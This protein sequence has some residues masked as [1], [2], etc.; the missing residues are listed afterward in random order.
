MKSKPIFLMVLAVLIVSLSCM[1]TTQVSNNSGQTQAPQLSSPFAAEATSPMSVQLAW[2]PVAG[3]QKYLLAVRLGD[4]EFFPIAELPADQTSFEDFP[5]PDNSELTYRLQS[6]TS[7]ATND[8]GTATVKTSEIEPNPL[9][10]QANDYAP[11]A[12]VPP[13]PDPN[14]PNVDPSAFY[15]P[16]FDPDHPESFDPANAMQQVQ[17][18]A[19]IGR[20]GG[21]LSITTPDNITYEL[22]FPPD[23]LEEST[24]ISLF[25]IETIDGLPFDGG[26]Q[27]AVRIEPDGLML[28]LPA[29]LRITQADAAPLPEGMVT[30]AFGF[31]GSGEE[32]HLLP[33]APAAQTGLYLGAGHVASLTAAPLRAGPLEKIALQQL[34][35]YGIGVA[36]PEKAAL[37]VKS[38]SPTGAEER[39]LNELAYGEA[40]PYLVPLGSRQGMATTKLLSLV[41]SDALDWGQMT[42]SLAQLE[43]LSRY[44]GKDPK[45]ADDLAKILDLL[46]DRLKKMLEANPGKCLTGD[47]S[48]AQAVAGKIL[49]AKP[50]SMY[51]V[52]YQKLD[53][54]L[55]K[56][57][58]GRQKKCTLFL[59][60]QS[61]ITED[62]KVSV[63]NDVLVTGEIGPLKFNFKNGK[64]FL[65]GQKD[66]V[67]FYKDVKISPYK[68]PDGKDWCEPWK[69][70]NLGS[71]KPKAIVTKIDLVIAEGP[72]GVL[73]EVI[74]SPMTI[75]DNTV[76]KGKLTCHHI[77]DTGKE[78]I[79]SMDGRIP[80]EKGSLWNGLFIA[81]HMTARKY[82]FVVLPA[83]SDEQIIARYISTRPSFSPGYGTWSE[84]TTFELVDKSPK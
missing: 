62:D 46:L 60:I 48:F 50:G 4:S 10:V 54:Q 32:F 20:E 9:T 73:Q 67:E 49:G 68:T 79:S 44:Y 78:I 53:P 80:A 69:P 15:P 70:Y 11:I 38:H 27:G 17:A 82:E 37:V 81:A 76:F 25:P 19:D 65:T 33:F 59:T 12:W 8:V 22:T 30:L 21:T 36:T 55:L 71:V 35:Q 23:A 58:A 28:D 2:K 5:V 63:K 43:I 40:D 83:G 57:V 84:D 3:V 75:E 26:L 72:G 51:A 61:K 66:L 16:G 74:L 56:A 39:L 13:T 47:D 24:F 34:K 31:D 14:N 45:L 64:V 52:L 29:T 41:K 6:V 42:T 7:S 18:S 1:S 77:D